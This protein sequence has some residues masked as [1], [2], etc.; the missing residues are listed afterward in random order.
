M[1]PPSTMYA[2]AVYLLFEFSASV[3]FLMMLEVTSMLTHD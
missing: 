2:R 1:V 3:R